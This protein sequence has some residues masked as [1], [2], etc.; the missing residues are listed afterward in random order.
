M[1]IKFIIIFIFISL[2]CNILSD[3]VYTK[4]P[5]HLKK[6][7]KLTIVSDENVVIFESDSFKEED[8]IYF[9][10][11]SFKFNNDDI[12]F[13]FLDN[14]N[15]S[16][17]AMDYKKSPEKRKDAEFVDISVI[18]WLKRLVKTHIELELEMNQM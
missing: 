14:S 1:K 2:I 18:I 15:P 6:D 11:T 17:F 5:T 12:K 10:I 16:S 7:G 8:K 9:K 4:Y 3:I 13:E